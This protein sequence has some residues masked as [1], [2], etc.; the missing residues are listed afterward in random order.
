MVF[1]RFFLPLALLA[2][3]QVNKADELT[4]FANQCDIETGVSV[5]D[6]NCDDP[7]ATEVPTTNQ[8][9]GNYPNAFCDR[10]NVLNGAC[11]AGSRFRV[12]VN[13]AD[14]YVVAH[15]RKHGLSTGKYGDVAVIQHNKKN[16]ATCFYQGA[17]GSDQNG[18]VNAPVK[19]IGPN[20]FWMKPAEIAA[21]GFQCVSCHD[22]GPIIRSP[23]LTQIGQRDKNGRNNEL[24]GARDNTFNSQSKPYYFVGK[25][26]AKW[27]AYSVQVPGN[28]CTVC[29]R[30]GVNNIGAGGTA[31]VF[32]LQATGVNAM[33]HK[34]VNGMASPLWMQPPQMDNSITPSMLLDYTK[35]ISPDPASMNAAKAINTCAQKFNEFNL[36]NDPNGCTIKQITNKGSVGIPGSFT[37]VWGPSAASEIQ[38]YGWTYANYRAKYDLIW[39]LG[40]R[41]F[42]LQPYV[43]NGT[44]LYNAVW[45]KSTASEV[46]VYGWSYT[47]Y[48][49]KYDALWP[50][51]W[52]LKII[53]PYV[54]NGNVYYT[55]V[56]QKSTEN[57]IQVYGWTYAD[58]RAKY[59][60]L[61]PQGWR[62]KMIQPYVVNGQVLYTAVWSPSTTNEVQVYGW[63][64]ADYRAKYDAL[65]PQG[66][67]LAFLQPYVVN[68][69]V[70]YTAVW[71]PST[72]GEIQVYGWGF[73]AFSKK[74]D[75][76]W[77]QGWRLKI[78]QTY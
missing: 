29:H 6:F 25:D 49:A 78:L 20:K 3:A 48:R 71:R 54:L 10:P 53:Q 41:L 52:R 57:E 2:M 4:D 9:L 21:S 15:C 63:S 67:R 64:Y 19:G 37:A 27:K 46:Q 72:A 55:A 45:R 68:G 39:P 31:R 75:E 50:Q 38:A 5:P 14:A 40:W 11:D 51:G 12:L 61:W 30:L 77:S 23:Y 22:N 74:Q 33:S 26:F 34:N 16:G 1:K 69:T 76:L 24:P 7:L 43:V 13:T 65:W 32:G 35:T 44:V 59:D 42:S 28:Q 18:A 60:Q 8:S 62:L 58:M 56:W 17:L 36:P 47:D 66:W 73:D 70:L